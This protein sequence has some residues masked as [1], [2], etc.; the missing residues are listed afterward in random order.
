MNRE[1]S[2]YANSRAENGLMTL[3]NLS[4]VI[5]WGFKTSDK[6]NVW[7][8]DII[9]TLKMACGTIILLLFI[10]HEV[11]STRPISNSLLKIRIDAC[12][13]KQDYDILKR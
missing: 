8:K 5:F 9:W 7:M 1:L 6:I 2:A 3:K 11:T 13:P 10:H 4:R 12:D